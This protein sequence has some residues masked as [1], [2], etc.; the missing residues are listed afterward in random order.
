VKLDRTSP[1]V[2]TS[3]PGFGLNV[4]LRILPEEH[5]ARWDEEGWAETYL[6]LARLAGKHEIEV[7]SDA[8]GI[9]VNVRVAFDEDVRETLDHAVN[10]IDAANDQ[11][12]T[13][14]DKRAQARAEAEKWWSEE[15]DLDLD[16]THE[17]GT[18]R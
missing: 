5:D 2:I 10:R 16:G 17:R 1:P 12:I 15:K 4:V 11:W 9:S 8:E 3:V 14:R 6:A 13:E 18:R 7:T